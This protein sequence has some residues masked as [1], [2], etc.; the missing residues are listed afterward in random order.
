[1]LYVNCISQFHKYTVFSKCCYTIVLRYEECSVVL[2]S[3][4]GAM[5]KYAR[6]IIIV[7]GALLQY[8]SMSRSHAPLFC[9]SVALLKISSCFFHGYTMCILL[10]HN[11]H[12][13]MV[14]PWVFFIIKSECSTGALINQG[15][16]LMSMVRSTLDLEDFN[17]K[18]EYFHLFCSFHFVFAIRR[19]LYERRLSFPRSLR[20]S[21]TF[22]LQIWNSNCIAANIPILNLSKSCNILHKL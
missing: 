20:Q 13:S 18:L 17:Q 8:Q 10:Y 14:K 9:T 19:F 5:L 12:F 21:S 3:L 6:N 4:H 2:I 7:H 11:F 1:M 22:L 15:H 16:S